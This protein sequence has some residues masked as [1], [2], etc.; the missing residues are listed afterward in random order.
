MSKKPDLFSIRADL[1]AIFKEKK[2][3]LA[4]KNS[5]AGNGEWIFPAIEPG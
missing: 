4:F 2:F 3:E 1:K 5:R